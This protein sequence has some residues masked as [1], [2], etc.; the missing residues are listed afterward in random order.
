MVDKNIYNFDYEKTLSEFD[1]KKRYS[2][3]KWL[4]YEKSFKSGKQGYVGIM[5][6]DK[7][8]EYV[9]KISQGIN[10]LVNHEYTVM[11]GLNEI[12]DFCPYFCKLYGNIKYDMPVE[13]KKKIPDIFSNKEKGRTI[14]DDILF[15]ENIKDSKKFCSF[16]KD[17]KISNDIIYSTIKQVILAVCI[18]QKTC[19]FTHYDL[20]SDNVLMKKCDKN[21]CVLIK[22]DDENQFLVP[23]YGYIPTIIDFGFSY[24]DSMKDNYLYPSMGHTE[25]GFLSDR[26][27]PIADPKL[28]MVTTSCELKE[29]RGDKYSKKYRT[30]TKNIFSP[31]SID[32]DSGWDNKDKNSISDSVVDII[33]MSEYSTDFIK[34]NSYYIVDMIQTLIILP[35]EYRDTKTVKESFEGFVQEF[36]KIENEVNNDFYLLYILKK[37]VDVARNEQ[38]D[39]IYGNKNEKERSLINFREEIM[40]FVKNISK[41][42]DI[43]EVKFEKLFISIIA[44]SRNIEG[45]FYN[46]MKRKINRK[47]KE[48]NNLEIDSCEEIY[49]CLEANIQ[50]KYEYSEKNKV[51][52][53]D[54]DKRI[55]K[56][57]NINSK[58]AKE[59]NKIHPISRGIHLYNKLDENYNIKSNYSHSSYSKSK[60]SK[61]SKDY[62]QK[63]RNTVSKSLS[64]NTENSSISYSISSEDEEDN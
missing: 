51:L 61:K 31:L 2:I 35:I 26:F 60:S 3:D 13:A 28:F 53:I 1:S 19:K 24:I 58:L 39:F 10:Y 4:K 25:V 21:L 49:K 23:T 52:V 59:L 43:K 8:N 14:K 22:I 38:R 33:E 12:K 57:I 11:K 45:I 17:E 47:N 20:H 6:S 56:T 41:K 34:N 27:D 37:I 44:F 32:W 36:T 7:G 5:K 42:I 46:M 29:E 30:I 50:N 9:I 16:I 55:N 54:C 63:M 18:A 40:K 64:T 48:Y 62:I 15:I